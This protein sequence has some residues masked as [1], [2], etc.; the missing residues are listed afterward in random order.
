M[1]VLKNELLG[2]SELEGASCGR[3]NTLKTDKWM[4]TFNVIDTKGFMAITLNFEKPVLL[5][6]DILVRNLSQQK[7]F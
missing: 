7:P 3:I 5:S 1:C 2:G 6:A 4:F